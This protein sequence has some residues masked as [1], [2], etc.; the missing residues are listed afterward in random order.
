MP[1]ETQPVRHPRSVTA[2]RMRLGGRWDQ[3]FDGRPDSIYNFGLEHAHNEGSSTVSAL[4]GTHSGSNP[5]QPDDRW[6]VIS[7][8]P[9]PR[10]PL[11]TPRLNLALVIAQWYDKW[12]QSRGGRDGDHRQ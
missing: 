6:M 7:S 5:S 11:G 1:P 4:L 3:R 9:Y 2:Q 12:Y 8:A 10:G